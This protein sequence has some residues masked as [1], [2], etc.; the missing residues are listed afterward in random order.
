MVALFWVS[1]AIVAYVYLG[2]P[3]LLALWARLR[4]L[5]APLLPSERP[6]VSIVIAARNEGSRLAP[7]LDNLLQL[8]YPSMRRQII[9]VSDGSTD[10]TL[11]VLAPYRDV[12]DVISIP[13]SGKA[14]A[15]NAGV[16]AARNELI[17]FADARQVFAPDALRELTAPFGATLLTELPL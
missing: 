1:C 13:P 15:L 2:Y 17:V 14:I 10:D 3:A 8:E 9:V 5:P 16:A 12:V 4:P 6:G 11:D 7:R